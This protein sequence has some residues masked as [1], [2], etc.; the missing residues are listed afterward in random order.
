MVAN[1]EG[2]DQALPMAAGGPLDASM[3]DTLDAQGQ[4][5]ARLYRSKTASC[6]GGQF[7]VRSA[8]SR[9][10]KADH[11]AYIAYDIGEVGAGEAPH[12]NASAVGHNTVLT[13]SDIY[14]WHQMDAHGANQVFRFA[15]GMMHTLKPCG[16]TDHGYELDFRDGFVSSGR[17]RR[18]SLLKKSTRTRGDSYVYGVWLHQIDC[19]LVSTRDEQWFIPTL[20]SSTAG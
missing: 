5:R 11:F 12:E 17:A 14:S 10:T 1:R 19:T 4:P 9:L 2:D 8:D 3:L 16:M 7:L 20:K 18:P 6:Q 15:I 13:I